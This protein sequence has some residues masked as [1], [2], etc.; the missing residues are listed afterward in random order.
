MYRSRMALVCSLCAV[1]AFTVALK[2]D[3][4]TEDRALVRFEGMLGRVVGIFGGKAA[5]EGV[6][7]T[8][9]IKGNRKAMMTDTTGQIIDLDEQKIY[10]LDIRRK[11]YKVTT[12][13]D[14]R[15]RMEEAQ[16]RAQEDARKQ[17]EQEKQ[18]KPAAP[19]A[20]DPN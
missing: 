2:A 16:R 18:E 5:R 9:A 10:E 17:Q 6:K 8:T 3:V 11:T 19:P 14:I 4:R 20:K 13:A 1:L 12:F 15:R 7:T